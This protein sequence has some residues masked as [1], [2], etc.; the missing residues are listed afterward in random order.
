MTKPSGA[1]AEQEG[2]NAAEQTE[3]E[4]D[5]NRSSGSHALI[6]GGWTCGP[7]QGP[8]LPQPMQ[9][10]RALASGRELP[11]IGCGHT[12]SSVAAGGECGDAFDQSVDVAVRPG[13]GSGEWGVRRARG[14]PTRLPVRP[15]RA[16][17]GC[18]RSGFASRSGATTAP[19][20]TCSGRMRRPDSADQTWS[21]TLTLTPLQ[22]MAVRVTATPERDGRPIRYVRILVDGDVVAEQGCNNCRDR[23]A[24][25]LDRSHTAVSVEA[26]IPRG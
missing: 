1:G 11:R 20:P 14:R 13:S 18:D 17:E 25:V 6:P 16:A 5:V 24:E 22:P 4:E 12:E 7:T 10:T 15:D 23:T 19:S 2:G 9:H 3:E 8:F 26:I 21:R